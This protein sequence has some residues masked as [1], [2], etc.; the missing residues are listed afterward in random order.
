MG[1]DRT[2]LAG[3]KYRQTGD[4][5]VLAAYAAALWPFTGQTPSEYFQA[6]A[7]HF[8]LVTTGHTLD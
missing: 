1:V 5:C 3:W 2:R 8:S 4:Q 6:Y 7:N